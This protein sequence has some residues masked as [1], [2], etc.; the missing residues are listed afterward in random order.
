MMRTA[1]L[2]LSRQRWLRRWMETSSFAQPLTRRFIAGRTLEQ[3][4][5]VCRRLEAENILA[6][7]DHLGEN[8]TSVEESRT[9]RDSYLEILDRIAA[10]GLRA[11]ISAKPTQLG[12][13]LGDEICRENFCT[14]VERAKSLASAVEIDMESSE[15]VDRTL[16]IVSAVHQQSGSVR[17]VIQAYLFRSEADIRCLNEAGIPVRLVK[18]AYREPATVAWPRKSDVD[19]SFLRLTR[20]LLEHG[21]NPAIATHDESIVKE[22]VS[23]IRSRR[24]NPGGFEF[25]MLYGIRRDLQRRL[26]AD[27]FRVRLYV[28]FG[29]AWYPYFMRRL[30]ERPANV[31][32][33]ARNLLRS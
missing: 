2:F 9:T 6:T 20:H 18:G 15:Y 33:L 25:Q 28:P 26:V 8:V 21:T 12:L 11:T 7:L 31:I 23:W 29:D 3:E 16:R 14:L 24:M 4:L 13:D 17:A 32:F 27:G 19:A 10:A 30:A 5:E 1:L 22:T